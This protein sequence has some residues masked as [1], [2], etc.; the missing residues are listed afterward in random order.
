[1]G[2]AVRR[3]RLRRRV[4]GMARDYWPPASVDI[5][6]WPAVR[7]EEMTLRK[8]KSEMGKIGETIRRMCE[9]SG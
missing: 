8:L 4:R 6:V 5:V 1:M 9:E 3:N 2:G 7:L